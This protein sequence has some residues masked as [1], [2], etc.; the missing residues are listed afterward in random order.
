MQGTENYVWKLK[1]GSKDGSFVISSCAKSSSEIKNTSSTNLSVTKDGSSWAFNFQTDGTAIIQN[2]SNEDRFLGYTTATSYAYKAYAKSNLGD[3]NYPH[4]I[5][6]YRLV[7]ETGDEGPVAPSVSFA[8]ESMSVEVGGTAINAISKPADLNVTYSTGNPAIATVSEDG[9]VTGVAEGETTITASW[10]AVE[11]TYNA[12]SKSFAVTVTAPVP[13]VVYEKVTDA[14]QLLDGNEYLLVNSDGNNAL[15]AISTTSTKYGTV[16]TIEAE[17]DKIEIKGQAVNVLTLKQEGVNWLFKTGEDYL[18][19]T[20]GNSLAT[21]STIS[22]NTKWVVEFANDGSLNIS[23]VKDSSRKLR[24]NSNSGSERFACYTTGQTAVTLYVKEGSAVDNRTETELAFS[25]ATAQGKVGEAFTAPTLTN[26]NNVDV[27][28]TSSNMDVATVDAKTGAVSIV[29][30]GTTTITATFDG[31][32]NYFGTAAS[33]TLTV[34]KAS[35]NAKFFVNGTE[36]TDAAVS[37]TEDE[38]I[39]FPEVPA[40][41]LGKTFVGWTTTEIDGTTNDHPEVLV[42]SATMGENDVAYYAVFANVTPGVSVEVT[43][44]LNRETTGVTGNSYSTWSGKKATS[45]AV[46]AGQSAGDKSSIQ[47]RSSNNNS[48]VISTTSGGKL[49]KVVVVWNSNTTNDRTLDVYGSNKAYSAATDLYN[50]SKQGTKLGSIVNGTSTELTVDGDYKYIG[51]R[52]NSGAMYLTSISIT[53]ESGTPETYSDYCTTVKEE[54]PVVEPAEPAEI[55]EGYYTIQNLGNGKYVNVAGRKTVTFVSD[56]KT[57]AGT[58]IKVKADD[59]KGTV[60]VLR[61]QGVDVPGYAEKA[62]RYVPKMVKLVADKLH[63]VGCGALLGTDGLDAIMAKFDASFDDHLYVEQGSEGVRL[64]GKTP[65]MEPVVEFYQENK[66]NVDAKLPMLE[67]FINDAIAKVL[68]KTGNRGAS[69]LTP[70]S[71]EAVWANMGKMLPEPKDEASKLQFLQEVLGNKE[72][73]WQFAYQT[74]MLYWTNLK[75]HPKFQDMKEQLGEYGQ[76]IDKVEYILPD[77]K[78]YLV[79]KDGKVDFIS[80]DDDLL[81]DAA[82]EWKLEE[83]KEFTLSIDAENELNGKYYTT[84]YT[85]FAYTLPEGV[86]AYKVTEVSKGGV[87]KKE[88]I[89]GVI[90]AQTP[91]LLEADAEGE[92]TLTLSTTDGT[93]PKD[94]LLKGPDYLINTYEIKTAQVVSLFEM[95]KSLLGESAYESYV[96]EYEHL[97]LRNAGT[98]NNKYFFGLTEEDLEECVY[99]NADGEEDCVARSLS[100]G[101]EKLGFYDNWTVKA[102]RAFLVS[103]KFDPVKL[104][105]KGD[106]NRDGEVTIADVNALV[107][108]VLGKATPE[109]DTERYDFDAADV[110][111][112][113]QFS[114]ADITALVNIILG[115]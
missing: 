75:N 7:E 79:Q 4:A 83:R 61:S 49:K 108:I 40:S 43:D 52:S 113:H 103:E 12:G 99:T 97:M 76:Y 84:L 110:N 51:L 15:G 70:F 10:N 98:V 2:K 46:Y 29:A 39:T 111:E 90:P 81:K 19:W 22:D 91:V 17:N 86:K 20:S 112:D 100:T 65:S 27:T 77:M 60:E 54:E 95:A 24:Y 41:I 66:A 50:T 73:V 80:Q 105:L 58:V 30:A 64:Y 92:K 62:M 104:Y 106:V 34:A 44:A 16:V 109:N 11:N 89:T 85:D 74:A 102:N 45:D 53:W 35:H 25:A 18:T 101:D 26:P 28:Y 1:K 5:V 82:A 32:E 59:G 36:L 47:L 14:K 21:A 6:V 63:A 68:E 56:T 3:N 38:A 71:L 88:A 9:T 69:I 107:E 114:V 37:V 33:Y 23:N 8:N 115:K 42:K 72:R 31:N 94:N 78:Y 48:G 87:A 67:Q 57:A 93:A 96:K 55:A 13:T